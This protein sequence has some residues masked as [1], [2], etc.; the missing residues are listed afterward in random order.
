MN[1]LSDDGLLR[2]EKLGNGKYYINE[3]LINILKK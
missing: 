2:K 1:K 3:A